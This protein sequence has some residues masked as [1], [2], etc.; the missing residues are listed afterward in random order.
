MLVIRLLF[1]FVGFRVEC[2]G[3]LFITC[4]VLTSHGLFGLGFGLLSSFCFAWGV[5]FFGLL[6]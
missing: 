6:V 4:L 3:C 5:G 2:L 1:C